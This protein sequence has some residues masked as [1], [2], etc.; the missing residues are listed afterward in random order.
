MIRRNLETSYCEIRKVQQD[1]S[2]AEKIL[3]IVAV[4]QGTDQAASAVDRFERH[5]TEEEKHAG[6]GYYWAYT[7]RIKWQNW[8][9]AHLVLF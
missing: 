2:G 5:L 8:R 3:G 1:T 9:T 4:V 7:S 6:F